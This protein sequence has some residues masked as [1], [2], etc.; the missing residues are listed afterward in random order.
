MS[1][2]PAEKEFEQALYGMELV[3]SLARGRKGTKLTFCR[4]DL[5][6]RELDF[7]QEESRVQEGFGRRTSS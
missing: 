3:D 5:N 1:N 2:L 4:A 7:V 6:P